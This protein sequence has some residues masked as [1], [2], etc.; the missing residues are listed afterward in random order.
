MNIGYDM[1]VGEIAI[2]NNAGEQICECDILV[3]L[4][5]LNI[6]HVEEPYTFNGWDMAI[7]LYD[8]VNNRCF[9]LRYSDIIYLSGNQGADIILKGRT[10]TE[11]DKSRLADLLQKIREAE[12]EKETEEETEEEEEMVEYYGTCEHCG[13]VL[14]T[15]N[16]GIWFDDCLLC[17]DCLDEQTRICDC[18]GDRIWNEDDEGDEDIILC[19]RCR[20][21]YYSRCDDCGRLI[22][23]D[24]ACY[25]D[26]EDYPYCPDCYERHARNY[27]HNYSYKP[28]PVFHGRGTMFFGVELELDE[29][30]EDDD[31]AEEILSCTDSDHL[32]IKHDGSLD[33]GMELVS[34]P[35]TLEYHQNSMPWENIVETAV[36]LGYRSHQTGT[37]GLHVHVNRKAFGCDRSEQD[38]VISRILYIVERFWQE[39]L[40]FSRRTE[41]QIDR[42]AARYGIKDNP[43]QVMDNAKKGGR[44]RYACINLCNYNTI[45]FRIFRGTLKYNTLIATL[46]MVEHICLTAMEM[47]DEE[48]TALSWPEFIEG[49]EHEELIQYLKERRLYVNEIVENEEEL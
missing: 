14:E 15:E 5:S 37:C 7:L 4:D 13:C 39:M 35:M 36:D 23:D 2:V 10:P 49:I 29:G 20:D 47:T 17:E 11:E 19:E 9:D 43:K 44:G 46:Q 48:I 16:D 6:L 31:K 18:C 22:H 41:Y 26:G 1:A 27:I 12:E 40:K 24:D 34:H 30:G 32:Y 38:E 8:K 25:V 33:D 21:N 3:T 42:W 45:E 28:N